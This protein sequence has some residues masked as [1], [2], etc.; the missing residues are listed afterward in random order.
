MDFNDFTDAKFYLTALL[1]TVMAAF[2]PHVIIFPWQCILSESSWERKGKRRE[3]ERRMWFLVM[4]IKVLIRLGHM[5]TPSQ[6]LGTVMNWLPSSVH[7]PHAGAWS[8][9]LPIAWGLWKKGVDGE[10]KRYMSTLRVTHCLAQLIPALALLH[11]TCCEGVM[12][13][14]EVWS[15]DHRRSLL[16]SITSH[17]ASEWS[18]P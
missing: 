18:T 8:W 3:R 2:R 12:A 16:I 6:L 9:A 5:S 13:Q 14:W 1:S 11:I 7:S 17:T 10:T 15:V 4:S